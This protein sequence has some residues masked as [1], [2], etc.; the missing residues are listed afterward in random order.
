MDVWDGVC[1][2]G[3]TERGRAFTYHSTWSA[4]L[5]SVDERDNCTHDNSGREPLSFEINLN[6]EK[7]ATNYVISESIH[8]F[9]RYAADFSPVLRGCE[10]YCC[11][12]HT[13]AYIHHLLCTREIL[14]RT[15]LMM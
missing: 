4:R 1:V 8:I 14:A 10:C 11:L 6:D 9:C 13:R 15:L 12:H 3:A 7:L 5:H 2:Y